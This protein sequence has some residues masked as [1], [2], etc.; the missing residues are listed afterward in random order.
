MSNEKH[1]NIFARAD[2]TLLWIYFI[3]VIA[4]W[5]NIYAAVFDENHR[6]IFDLDTNY[7]RQ[8]IWIVSSIILLS[9]VMLT[10]PKFFNTF[11]YLIYGIVILALAGVIVAGKEIAGSR[12]WFQIGYFSIQPAEFAKLATSLVLASYLG[13]IKTHFEKP[14]TKAMAICLIGLPFF[15]IIAQNETGSALV[16]VSFVL[17]LY[18]EGLSGIFLIIGLLAA[19]LFVLTLLVNEYI[20][21]GIILLLPLLYYYS[22]KDKKKIKKWLILLAVL[23]AGAFVLSVDYVFDNVLQQHQKTRINVLLGK[24]TDLKG[25]GYNVH[26]SMIAIGSG[27]FWGKGY[28]KGTQTKYNYVPEQ[29]TDFIF[30][31]IGE[32]WGFTGSLVIIGLYLT[33]LLRIIQ[34]AERQRAAFSRIYGYC[35]AS[36]IFFHVAINLGMTIGLV[37]VIGIPL[38]FLSYG[39]SSLWGFTLLLFIFIKLDAH[40]HELI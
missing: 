12:S 25:A 22:R 39:G 7:G 28:M 24:E 16:F 26:Q 19:I 33:L 8:M 40:R 35:V 9:A 6:S 23:A 3:L 31:T 18:R 2:R 37:P 5:L 38:P 36:I 14:L 30:C 13:N 1:T 11:A 10:E 32:E 4:G 21:L 29:S 17:M 27:G 15:L 34:L 20:L